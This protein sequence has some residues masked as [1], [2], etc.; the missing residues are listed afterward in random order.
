[1]R[2]F[3]VCTTD[4]DLTLWLVDTCAGGQWSTDFD[5]AVWWRTELE[6]RAELEACEIEGRLG[7]ELEIVPV[8]R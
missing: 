7:V 3:A 4:P 2:W 8:E 5:R 1:M 6:A